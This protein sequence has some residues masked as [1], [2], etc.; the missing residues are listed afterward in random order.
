MNSNCLG[1]KDI[2]MLN[3]A[4]YFTN[5]INDKLIIMIEQLEQYKKLFNLFKMHFGDKIPYYFNFDAPIE[6]IKIKKGLM[7]EDE[8]EKT[9]KN[10]INEINEIIDKLI[11]DKIKYDSNYKYLFNEI[12][13]EKEFFHS[14]DLGLI[15]MK[16]SEISQYKH[17]AKFMGEYMYRNNFKS[18]YSIDY[19]DYQKF[20]INLTEADEHLFS[21]LLYN[22][23]IF[24][25]VDY[26]RKV[27]YP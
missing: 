12:Y 6:S 26:S 16:L 25:D 11:N 21:I 15:K 7:S 22:K 27:F 5:S 19:F 14:D 23:K 9:I 24:L 8:L 4:K 1:I 13:E 10:S 2:N 18:D 20:N 3:L 17:Y